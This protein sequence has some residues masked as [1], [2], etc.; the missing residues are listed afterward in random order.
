MYRD[1][2]A[3]TLDYASSIATMDGDALAELLRPGLGSF[4]DAD[5]LARTVARQ[6]EGED[7]GREVAVLLAGVGVDAGLERI[8]DHLGGYGV[9]ISIVSFEVFEPDGGSRLLI[10]EVTEEQTERRGPRPRRT[11]DEIRQL[12]TDEG[13]EAEFERLMKMGLQVGL[14]VRTFPRSIN[15]V[16]PWNRT[17]RL[18]YARPGEGGLHIQVHAPTFVDF[19]HRSPRKKPMLES[20]RT[21]VP[22]TSRTTNLTRASTRSRRS[23]RRCRAGTKKPTS[24]KVSAS[25]CRRVSGDFRARYP[26]R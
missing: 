3:Q 20:G 12:A 2:L 10:R 14:V 13:V 8:V 6:L 4:G 1:A 24:T 23:C 16:H 25:I 19:S 11:V 21:P 26:S 9:P 5:E 17:R 18:I 22:C 15:M 7:A